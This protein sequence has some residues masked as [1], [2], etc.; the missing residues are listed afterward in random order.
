MKKLLFIASI[1]VLL[2]SPVIAS[3]EEFPIICE[4]KEVLN[5]KRPVQII[6]LR[7]DMKNRTVNNIPSTVLGED[8]IT[9]ETDTEALT[10]ILPTMDITLI[11]KGQGSDNTDVRYTGICYHDKLVF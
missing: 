6:F 5:F 1:L 8:I 3:G 9:Y 7:V 4:L 10:I 2:A 11:R